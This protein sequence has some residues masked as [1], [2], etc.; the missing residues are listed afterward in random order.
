[1]GS[2]NI[3]CGISNLSI[4]EG[5]EVG[6]VILNKN[7]STTDPND[8]PIH[9]QSYNTYATDL[10]APFLPP[11]YGK[12]RENGRIVEIQESLT[13]ELLE[14]HFRR[15]AEVVL[16]CIY[17]QS[18]YDYFGDIFAN[19]FVPEQTWE[20]T[21]VIS[22]DILLAHGFIKDEQ[23]SG[24]YLFGDYALDIEE[25]ADGS[26]KP[27]G[28]WYIWNN[29]ESEVVGHGDMGQFID[30][31]MDEF[32]QVTGQF[33]GFDSNDYDVVK[34][35]SEL[36]VMFF[37]KEAYDGM[38]SYTMKNSFNKMTFI[39][40]EFMWDKMMKTIEEGQE[41]GFSPEQSS[42]IFASMERILGETSFPINKVAELKVYEDNYDVFE[43]SILTAVMAS[44]NKIFLPSDCDFHKSK[45]DAMYV[46]S[47]V[48][49]KIETRRNKEG[50]Y[51]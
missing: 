45:N 4:N 9:G 11:V 25:N 22:H 12:Y 36:S 26:S 32:S 15:P 27:G 18:V 49:R 48:A 43:M 17:S 50:S 23:V 1:M 3:T 42:V 29:L 34:T 10:F 6:F 38:K 46:L 7:T 14:N 30:D 39:N 37:L 33:P 44:V 5:D 24:R 51:E 40:L 28:L 19:Y 47:R 41:D 2:S 31:I 21:D 8:R 13:T 16:N 35:L 20:R